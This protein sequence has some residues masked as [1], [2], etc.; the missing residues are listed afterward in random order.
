MEI[1]GQIQRA[2]GRDVRA[3]ALEARILSPNG[4]GDDLLKRRIC[5]TVAAAR[6]EVSRQMQTKYGDLVTVRWVGYNEELGGEC[7]EL[8]ERT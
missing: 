1:A 8:M 6:A 3:G 2:V 4:Y 5:R 7:G